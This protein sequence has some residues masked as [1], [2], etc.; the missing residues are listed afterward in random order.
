[1]PA[2]ALAVIVAAHRAGEG[3]DGAD[4]GAAGGERGDLRADVEV[5]ALDAHAQGSASRHRREEGDLARTG[6]AAPSA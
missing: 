6:D 4:I 5:L 3:D 1:M 2:I